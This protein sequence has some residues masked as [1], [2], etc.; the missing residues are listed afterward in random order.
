MAVLL[1]LLKSEYC[2]LVSLFVY[3]IKK[4][5]LFVKRYTDINGN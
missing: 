1:L 5:K 4:I 3:I 2:L